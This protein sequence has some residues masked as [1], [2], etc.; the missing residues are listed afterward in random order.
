MEAKII[1]LCGHLY[2]G[3]CHW[4]NRKGVKCQYLNSQED[5][6]HF[7]GSYEYEHNKWLE[8]INKNAA[9]LFPYETEE[10]CPIAITRIMKNQ[11]IDCVRAGYVKGYIQ[12][13]EDAIPRA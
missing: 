6:P 2:C 8:Q 7:H 4:Y 12:G 9:E 11:Y 1:S 10:S 13:H 5:C 3:E